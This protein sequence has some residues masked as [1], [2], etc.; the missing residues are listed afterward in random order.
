MK[1]SFQAFVNMKQCM[2]TMSCIKNIYKYLFPLLC[3]WARNFL[4]TEVNGIKIVKKENYEN[5]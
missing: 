5:A 1:Y 4:T 3:Y 2:L